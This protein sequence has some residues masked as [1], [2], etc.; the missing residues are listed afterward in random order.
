MSISKILLT[1]VITT[2]ALSASTTTGEEL[3]NS[4]CSICHKSSMPQ[5]KNE[6]IA[7]LAKGVMFHLREALKDDAKIKEHMADFV[8]NPTKEKAICKSVQKFGL[9][10]SQKGAVTKE[11]V[12]KI[13]DYMLKTF[14]MTPKGHED[15][16]SGMHKGKMNKFLK[17]DANSD[18]KISKDELVAEKGF[19]A[20]MMFGKVDANS[21]GSI[22][23]EEFMEFSGK[24]HMK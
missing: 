10:P 18:G 14:K 4:K 16:Q 13:A 15:M 11:E 20:N 2:F 8:L 19:M 7:P 3:F 12:E 6:M 24:K 23:K 22:S 1:T 5:N 21:D 17:I 9:M